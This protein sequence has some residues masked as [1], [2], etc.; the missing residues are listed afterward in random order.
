MTPPLDPRSVGGGGA[1]PNLYPGISKP[2]PDAKLVAVSLGLGVQSTGML[3]MASRGL[4]QPMPNMAFVADT[5]DEREASWEAYRWLASDNVGLGIPMITATRGNI[6]ADM[7]AFIARTKRRVAN[8]P[9]F[10]RKPDGTRGQINRNCTRDYKIRVVNAEVRKALGLAP[11]S[12][13]PKQP[14]V[15]MWIGITTDEFQ[16][17]A[18]SKQP[19][20]YNRH[21]LIEIGFSR[22]DMNLWVFRNFGIWLDASGCVICPFRENA[23]WLKMK[24]ERPHEFEAACQ[25]DDSLEAGLPGIDGEV[26]LHA[27]LRRLRTIDFERETSGGDLLAGGCGGE[28]RT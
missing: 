17:A 25:F 23:E 22:W 6:R 26:F 2:L 21:P 16:R 8:P 18:V 4:I 1:L 19:H 3:L 15:E 24:R 20:I 9:L 7:D 11:R 10:V 13:L 27:S 28:C 14:V 12:R 5:G